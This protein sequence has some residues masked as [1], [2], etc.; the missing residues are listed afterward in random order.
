MEKKAP[1]RN[2]RNNFA[3]AVLIELYGQIVTDSSTRYVFV[4][5]NVKGFSAPDK[6]QREPH[7]D[8]AAYFS[9]MRSRYFIKLVDAPCAVRPSEFAEAMYESEFTMEPRKASE[10]SEAIQELTDRIWY[11]RHVVSRNKI[12]ISKTKII[13]K[14]EFGPEHYRDSAHDK[15][16]VDENLGGSV[17][18]GLQS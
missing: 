1:F 11:D 12:E 4:S 16:V 3:D 6:D 9:K 14:K 18:V 10:I 13:P 15:F 7:P 17:A 5:H 8:F 2:G